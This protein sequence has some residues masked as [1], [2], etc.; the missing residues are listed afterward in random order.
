MPTSILNLSE[1]KDDKHET[2]NNYV[3]T[4]QCQTV[5]K[6]KRNWMSKQ[7]EFHRKQVFKREFVS[8]YVC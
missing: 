1:Y 4:T 2:A 6:N 7:Q 8:I 3:A 5:S